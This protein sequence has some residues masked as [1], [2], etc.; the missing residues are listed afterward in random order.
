MNF[1]KK[2]KKAV[3]AAI[4]YG[5]AKSLFFGR[6]LNEA[7]KKR[8][9]ATVPLYSLEKDFATALH[10]AYSAKRRYS[11]AEKK[12]LFKILQAGFPAWRGGDYKRAFVA[13]HI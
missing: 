2:A 3:A 10:Q 6:A 7:Q 8:L 13:W 4:V 9:A 12:R 5:K 11:V 1:E